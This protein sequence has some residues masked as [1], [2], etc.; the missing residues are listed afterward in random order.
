MLEIHVELP[1]DTKKIIEWNKAHPTFKEL[2]E[3]LRQCGIASGNKR[4][5]VEVE[6][7]GEFLSPDDDDL[8]DGPTIRVRASRIICQTSW[9]RPKPD[10][11][12]TKG[13]TS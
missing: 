12:P 13:N 2:K 9:E 10:R 11:P 7:Q 3:R 8:V 6:R 5:C 1:A 4:W